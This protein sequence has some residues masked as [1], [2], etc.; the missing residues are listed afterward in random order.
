MIYL[1]A[2]GVSLEGNVVIIDEA[3]NLIDA[4][5]GVHSALLSQ[6]YRYDHLRT[7]KWILS[8]MRTTH[9]LHV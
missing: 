1:Q 2:L 6:V 8:T 7:Y 3:H 4:I 9:C 5:N